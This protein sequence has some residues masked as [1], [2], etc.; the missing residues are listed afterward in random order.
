MEAEDEDDEVEDDDDDDEG[1]NETEEGT[2]IVGMLIA[3]D[4]REFKLTFT[5]DNDLPSQTN[6]TTL[7]QSLDKTRSPEEENHLLEEWAAYYRASADEYRRDSQEIPE[8]LP[9]W[10]ISVRVST[11]TISGYLYL[12]ISYQNGTEARVVT[13]MRGRLDADTMP[14]ILAHPS[15]PGHVYAQ[16]S[17]VKELKQALVNL[18]D[19]LPH[20][21]L[22]AVPIEEHGGLLDH[23]QRFT[24]GTWVRLKD[25]AHRGYRRAIARIVGFVEGRNAW[26]V[27]LIRKPDAKRKTKRRRTIDDSPI[28]HVDIPSESLERIDPSLDD[29]LPF[30]KLKL[31]PSSALR[32]AIPFKPDDPVKVLSGEQAGM[33]G[34]ISAVT[35]SIAQVKPLGHE[36]TCLA[37][38]LSSIEPHFAPGNHIEVLAGTLKGTT[39]WVVKSSG[40]IVTIQVT[41][42]LEVRIHFLVQT[43]IDIFSGTNSHPPRIFQTSGFQFRNYTITQSS[44]NRCSR[45]IAR[46]ACTCH[47]PPVQRV[48][49]IRQSHDKWHLCRL[50]GLRSQGASLRS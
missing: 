40:G 31:A 26:T 5:V 6:Y 50:V 19:V 27:S 7:Y 20:A 24:T 17:D 37:V 25:G 44:P 22:T 2:D 28:L 10:D 46:Q 36:D 8:T 15:I 4:S 18:T 32:A 42:L 12:I 11:F 29:I 45:S 3:T 47:Q 34:T 1:D 39:G 9:L 13:I 49:W 48:F 16:C 35:G 33:I 21:G 14:N 41:P 43:V 30:F 23:S 38:S